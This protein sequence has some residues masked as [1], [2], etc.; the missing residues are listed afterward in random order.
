MAGVDI[1]LN[2]QNYVLAPREDGS[3][4]STRPTRQFVQKVQDS[5]QTRPDSVAGYETFIHPNLTHGFGRSRINSDAAFDPK[6]YRKFRD[7]TCDTRWADAVYLP[8]LSESATA[9]NLDIARASVEFKGETNALFESAGT[10]VNRQF[11][12]ANDTW[13]N[14]GNVNFPYR[15]ITSASASTG[16]SGYTISHTTVGEN[17]CLVVVLQANAQFA[18]PSGITYD[19]TSLTKAG[20]VVGA[21]A[22]STSVA[23]YYLANPTIGTNNI[24]ISGWN[25][26]G[27]G[28]FSGGDVAIASAINLVGIDQDSPVRNTETTSVSPATSITDDITTVAGDLVIAALTVD[29]GPTITAG[30]NQTEIY[31]IIGSG[32][33]SYNISTETATTTTTTMSYD[34]GASEPGRMVSVAF[35]PGRSGD[36]ASV[37]LDMITHKNKLIALVA[38]EETH[39]VH[40]SEDGAT[41]TP[42]T[43]QITQNLLAN[44]ITSDEN[45]DAGLLAEINNELVALVWHEDDGTITAFTSTN[46]GTAFGD[47]SNFDIGSTNGPQGVAVYPDIDSKNKLYVGTAEGLYIVDT[48]V[49][50]WT[51]ELVF[52]M[53]HSTDN[54]RRMVVHEGSLWFAQGVDNGTP[55]PIYRLT[56]QGNS[57]RIESGYGLNTG[58]GVVDDMLGPVKWMRSSGD[59]LFISVGGG[60]ANRK[61]R[62][63]SWNGRGWHHM[64]RSTTA[65]QVINWFDIGSGD[66]STLR[67][68]YG[69]KTSASASSFKFLEQ[70]LVNPRSGVTIKREDDSVGVT[71]FIDL[72]YIDLGMPHETKNF[73]RA[74]VNAESL[75]ASDENILIKFG[76]DGA[77][78]T[79]NTLGTFTDSVTAITFA[80]NAGVSAKS[81]G[82]Q[83][84][85]TR[86]ST[87]TNTP[88]LKDIIVEGM[89]VPGNGNLTYQHEMVIDIDQTATAL[90][91][92]T[93]TI[94]D[95]LKTLLATVTLVDFEFGGES[96]KVAVDREASGFLTY[97]DGDAYSSAPN[98]LAARRGVLRLVLAERIPLS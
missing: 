64:T 1:R 74:H 78:R 2:S 3:K 72:P 87:N 61:A 7:S 66:D 86:G 12:G 40:T 94:Y 32:D 14:G 92:G 35:V 70:P 18:D 19:G 59:Q 6:E 23:V 46:G 79:G 95:N 13:E 36:E 67:L 93:E 98:S 77:V 31:D 5:G 29:D 16:A 11:T 91:V 58:D 47:E 69:I 52:P 48:S 82:M 15:S 65:N 68:H 81:I 62:I 83:I 96:R 4:I 28:N 85:L 37:A 60:A 24:I 56:V 41:W 44:N 88:K 17:R 34:F 51:F 49:S 97:L 90:D 63:L 38:E 42:S 55:A 22:G 53:P 39:E 8:I 50:D 9:T 20:S 84:N 33:Y 27:S 25:K 73:L 76:T 43:T 30:A 71:G 89:V 10:V 21:G 26:G 75:D 57:R 54:C 45:I 80:S